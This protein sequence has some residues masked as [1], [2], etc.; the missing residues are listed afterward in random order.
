MN[1]KKKIEDK[2]RKTQESEVDSSQAEDLMDE[3]AD[4]DDL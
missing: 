2:E 3:G 4:Q 1:P